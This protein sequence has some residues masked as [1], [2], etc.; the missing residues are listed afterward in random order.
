ME[1]LNQKYELKPNTNLA[2]E[3]HSPLIRNTTDHQTASSINLPLIKLRK[4]YLGSRYD[5][6]I[7]GEQ[8]LN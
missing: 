3:Q 6:N 1:S 2:S 5:Q 8:H 4:R 7:V